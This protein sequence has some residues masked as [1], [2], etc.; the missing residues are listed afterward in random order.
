MAWEGIRHTPY[1]FFKTAINNFR[2]K[3]NARRPEDQDGIQIPTVY[4][5]YRSPKSPG[6]MAFS[7]QWGVRQ[8]P[9][10]MPNE[11][12]QP[13]RDEFARDLN[14]GLAE[15]EEFG[16]QNTAP[17]KRGI[18]NSFNSPGRVYDYWDGGPKAVKGMRIGNT[19]KSITSKNAVDRMKLD[20]EY[21]ERFGHYGN[22]FEEEQEPSWLDKI[23][24]GVSNFGSRI[25]SYFRRP[26]PPP[27]QNQFQG[28]S[29]RESLELKDS[30]PSIR[31]EIG[32]GDIQGI[33]TMAPDEMINGY[34][35][36]K[37]PVPMHQE[38]IQADY[39]N[40]MSYFQDDLDAEGGV[41][42]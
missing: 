15:D 3:R 24:Q 4:S 1:Q 23:K 22:N 42:S 37:E 39:S 36:D 30:I 20:G 19:E 17:I 27:Q 13:E 18:I 31:G 35:A 29:K 16:P 8:Y 34:S 2:Y 9:N 40:P 11:W 38:P 12:T 10:L 28:L 25:G 14:V 33:G 21:D 5:E 26:S 7:Q 6:A 32:D 41:R